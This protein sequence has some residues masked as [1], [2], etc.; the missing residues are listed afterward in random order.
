MHFH[1]RVICVRCSTVSVFSTPIPDTL[2]WLEQC[3]DCGIGRV[4]GEADG[5][6][7]EQCAERLV[8]EVM[9][10]DRHSGEPA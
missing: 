6:V 7:C 1:E 8:R 2:F 5:T 10:E 9:E 3:A 4:I